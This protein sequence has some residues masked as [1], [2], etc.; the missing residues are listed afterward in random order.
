MFVLQGQIGCI[1]VTKITLNAGITVL[2]TP[3]E[4]GRS[5]KGGKVVRRQQKSR[6]GEE[7]SSFGMFIVPCHLS[8]STSQRDGF[9]TRTTSSQAPFQQP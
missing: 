4:D 2:M 7:N 3:S 8:S 6:Q 5:R 9:M 1:Y